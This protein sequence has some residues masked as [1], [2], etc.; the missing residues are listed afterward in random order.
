MEDGE[1][2]VPPGSARLLFIDL[3]LALSDEENADSRREPR[4]VFPREV[5]LPV[6]LDHMAETLSGSNHMISAG[7]RD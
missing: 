4:G 6:L 1:R 3:V 5:P 2:C 7:R